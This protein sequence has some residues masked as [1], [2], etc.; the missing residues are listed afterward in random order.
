MKSPFLMAVAE[1]MRM[2]NYAEKTIKAYIYWTTSYIH[3]NQKKHSIECHNQDVE[4]FEKQRY[5][6]RLVQHF[7]L[8]FLNQWLPLAS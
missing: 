5:S 7:P 8:S 4:F 2:K 1:N 3:F 6:L